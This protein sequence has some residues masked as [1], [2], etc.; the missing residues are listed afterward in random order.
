MATG[1]NLGKSKNISLVGFGSLDKT[2]IDSVNK[3]IAARIKRIN[4]KIDYE[5][6]RIRL[7]IHKRNKTFMHELRAEL[8][9]RP[10]Q[11][12][13]AAVQHK[14]LYRAVDDVIKHLASEIEHKIKKRQSHIIKR[15]IRKI[16]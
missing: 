10:G 15:L 12:V 1:A 13:S 8:L 5:L 3:V 16:T 11:N 6:L 7:K 2:E 14:N 9:I 4:N